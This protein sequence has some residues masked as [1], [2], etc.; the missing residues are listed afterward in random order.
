LRAGGIAV[1]SVGP[2]RFEGSGLTR[3]ALRGGGYRPA[4]TLAQR[5]DGVLESLRAPGLAYLYWG[6]VDK[7]GHH[8]GWGSMQW[9]DEVAAVDA[10]LSRLVRNVPKGTL[11]LVTADHGMV[12]V[13]RRARWDVA[14]DPGLREGVALVAGEPRAMQLHLEPGAEAADVVERW[15]QVLGNRALVVTRETAIGAGLFG[16]LDER[17]RPVVGDVVVAMAGRATVVDSRTQ[18]PGSM[19]LVGVH[20]S[21]TDQEM[22]VPLLLAEG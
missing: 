12:D 16:E 19:D 22:S 2:Q 13:D 20:G 17:V 8:H 3:A 14:T 21:L 9:G 15:S 7:A 4:E 18:T 10:E 11:V 1:T 5:V 6:D